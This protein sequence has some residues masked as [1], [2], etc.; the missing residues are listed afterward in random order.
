[1]FRVLMVTAQLPTSS[2]PASMIFVLRQVE[3]LRRAGIEVDVLEIEGPKAIKYPL[4][5]LRLRKSLASVDIVH[6]HYGYS[7]WVARCQ[8]HKPVVISFI[9]SDLLGSR[10]TNGQKTLFGR[11]VVQLNR[12]FART[13]D[14]VIVQSPQMAQIVAPVKADIISNGV[15]IQFFQPC[16]Q[17][18]AKRELGWPQYKRYILF[19][20]SPNRPEKNYPLA[21]AVVA[22]TA[23]QT[24]VP[25]ELIP[26]WN[27]VPKQ[28]SLYMNACDA[29]LMTSFS[30]GS[31]NVVREAMACNLPV[32]SV[33]VGDVPELLSGVES[34]AI[35]PWQ[36]EALA[37]ALVTV[38][39]NQP[40]SNGRDSLLRKRL[41]LESVAMKIKGVYEEVLK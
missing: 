3:A 5:I 23:K 34:C 19:P 32:V 29:M 10:N 14:A 39:K 35:R 17:I 30:E 22:E 2:N 7:G 27:V 40:R 1:M 8:R 33:P 26:L 31:P 11:M 18:S 36:A 13:T 6:A 4:S 16:E 38:L 21:K 24:W 25:I 28:V 41:D 37:E 20:S 9:G 12:L 15:D